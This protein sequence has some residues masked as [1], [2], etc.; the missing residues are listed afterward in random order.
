MLRLFYPCEYLDSVF[1]ID[2]E[3]LRAKGYKAVIFDIDNTLVRHGYESNARVDALFEEI[4]NIGLKTL[5]LSNNSRE[6]IE[7]FLENIDSLYIHEANKP[8]P[9]NYLKAV[10]M[11]EVKKSEAVF[12]GDQVFTDIFGANLSGIDSI[13]VKYLRDPDETYIGKRRELEKLILGFYEKS[14]SRRRGIGDIIKKEG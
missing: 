6:R 14:R 2:Y 11:L 1:Q 7:E 5:L 3:K 4:H 9:K 13:L 8:L 12:I 10:K